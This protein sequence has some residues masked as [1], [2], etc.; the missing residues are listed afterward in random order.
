MKYLLQKWNQRCFWEQGWLWASEVFEV[1]WQIC[2][3]AMQDSS[4]L[5]WSYAVFW[6][7]IFWLPEKL[8]F[9]SLYIATVGK[10]GE[11][12]MRV[13]TLRGFPRFP[14][15]SSS[16][17]QTLPSEAWNIQWLCNR[18]HSY[19]EFSLLCQLSTSYFKENS[20]PKV[21]YLT[22]MTSAMRRYRLWV[23][24][25]TQLYTVKVCV[26][27]LSGTSLLMGELLHKSLCV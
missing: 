13:L 26:M 3:N 7:S 1:G 27:G 15:F 24:C 22:Y 12:T 14:R 8:L 25:W 17:C 6:S 19:I 21:E 10:K 23:K 9:R 16:F 4:Y 2:I 5:C 20:K 18:R 11:S